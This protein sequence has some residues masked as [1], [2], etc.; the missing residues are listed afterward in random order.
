[1]RDLVGEKINARHTNGDITYRT[2]SIIKMG[3][4]ILVESVHFM[5]QIYG[6]V[7]YYNQ[8]DDTHVIECRKMIN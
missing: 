6:N 8:Y 1:M 2:R 3:L 4:L 7:I 5:W